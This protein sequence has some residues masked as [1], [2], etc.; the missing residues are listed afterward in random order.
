MAGYVQKYG[1]GRYR[2]RYK[3]YSR[4]VQAKSDREAEKHLA[5]FIAEIESGNFS[6][7]SKVTFK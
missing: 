2:L 4:Y 6:Q 5:K 7:P 1:E 3:G